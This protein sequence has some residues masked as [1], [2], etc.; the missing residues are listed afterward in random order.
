[1][2]RAGT[3][4]VSVLLT[5]VGIALAAWAPVT[6]LGNT[7]ASIGLLGGALVGAAIALLVSELGWWRERHSR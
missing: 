2:G 7:G 3:V 5:G 4:I 1:M 6:D